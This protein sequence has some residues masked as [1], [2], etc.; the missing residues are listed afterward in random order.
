MIDINA[1]V[2][3]GSG[4][5]GGLIMGILFAKKFLNG[6]VVCPAQT[7]LD[8]M[9]NACLL[10]REAVERNTRSSDRAADAL[11]TVVKALTTMKGE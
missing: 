10:L 8:E 5:A 11:L 9:H 2:G 4:A 7:T 6:K 3:G 1:L